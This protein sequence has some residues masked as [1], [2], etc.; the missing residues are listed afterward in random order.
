MKRTRWMLAG[1]LM[2][3]LMPDAA[4]Q[5]DRAAKIAAHFEA[6][7][8]SHDN[9]LALVEALRHGVPVKLFAA[10][11]ATERAVPAVT[12]FDPPSGPM[13]WADVY[14]ALAMAQAA[15]QRAQITRPAA[16]QLEA[17]LVGGV[18]TGGEG[19]SL[20]LVGILPLHAAGVPWNQLARLA[21]P[22]PQ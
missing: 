11:A 17:A 13:E 4:A 2:L 21:V 20:I 18:I 10:G 22:R 5:D 14:R 7:A 15:L 16:E 1:F 9:A 6:L 3:G 8:G 19:Q 12:T